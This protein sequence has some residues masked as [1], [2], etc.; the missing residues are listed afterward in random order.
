MPPE[1]TRFG[2]RR[3][4]T[5]KTAARSE[6]S[7]VTHGAP[8]RPSE[9][10]REFAYAST[11]SAQDSRRRSSAC[12]ALVQS[13][14][15]AVHSLIRWADSH[16]LALVEDVAI[17]RELCSLMTN[18]LLEGKACW[19]ADRVIAGLMFLE[20]HSIFSHA[21]HPSGTCELEL[22]Q[23][24]TNTFHEYPERLQSYLSRSRV[25]WMRCSGGSGR[26]WCPRASTSEGRFFR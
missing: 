3:T 16:D 7:L 25:S 20:T 10:V 19:A 21:W 22:V 24:S 11:R 18:C 8:S 9:L 15:G 4:Q 12:G 26:R 13:Y 2:Q 6:R 17:D 5:T 23:M 1:S 14:C